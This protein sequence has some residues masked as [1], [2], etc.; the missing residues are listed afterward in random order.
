MLSPLI[1]NFLTHYPVILLIL[2]I[3]YCLVL[4]IS[5]FLALRLTQF[6]I[7]VQH[8]RKKPL[9]KSKPAMPRL[10]Y[11]PFKEGTSLTDALQK[12]LTIDK[13]STYYRLSH[14]E[15]KK[16]DQNFKNL[17]TR[18]LYDLLQEIAWFYF[19]SIAFFVFIIINLSIL[20]IFLFVAE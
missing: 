12:E 16:I 2:I 8:D 20:M 6:T 19:F 17:L 7:K 14:V 9:N 13:N 1:D 10:F 11:P 3:F 18:S 4:L 5:L 15:F